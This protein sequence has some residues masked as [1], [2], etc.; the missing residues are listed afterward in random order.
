MISDEP[1]TSLSSDGAQEPSTQSGSP[2]SVK[3]QPHRR[4][5]RHALNLTIA[6]AI[7]LLVTAIGSIA[8]LEWVRPDPSRVAY[9][10]LYVD[11][12]KIVLAGF[13]VAMLGILIPAVTAEARYDF[14]RLKA[15]RAS[16]S[17]AKTG[18]DYLKLRIAS[19][20]LAEAS[21]H[22]QQVHFYKHQ[23]ELYDELQL[24]LEKRY[25]PEEKMDVDKWDEMMYQKLFLIR[26]VLEKEA[27][28]WDGM[29]PTE[30]IKLIST[31][32]P[33]E[34]DIPLKIRYKGRVV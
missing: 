15:S 17:R 20:K 30:R 9:Y 32:L 23:A 24:H 13:L 29:T 10:K 18:M 21:A 25:P 33:S 26:E 22:V 19:M 31:Y 5:A 28:H 8:F 1:N 14:E 16:Y 4:I 11:I 6:G 34:P 3:K 7:V 12:F 2:D 27:E